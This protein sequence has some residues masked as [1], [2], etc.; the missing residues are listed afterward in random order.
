MSENLKFWNKE[1]IIRKEKF[2]RKK[3]IYIESINELVGR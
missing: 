2:I 1:I 3:N